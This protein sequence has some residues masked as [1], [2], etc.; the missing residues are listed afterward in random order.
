MFHGGF[1]DGYGRVENEDSLSLISKG[2]FSDGYN[3]GNSVDLTALNSLGGFADG[4]SISKLN[5]QINISSRGGHTDGYSSEFWIRKYWT[6]AINSVWHNSTNWSD[7]LVPNM[8]DQVIIPADCLFYPI[9]SGQRLL[10]GQSGSPLDF[11][12]NS[13]WIQNNASLTGSTTTRFESSNRLE[14]DG[15]F[16]WKN[17]SLYSI[18][19]NL[20]ATIKVG[21]TGALEISQ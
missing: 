14:I 3:L 19:N 20:G 15:N 6:G 16:Y 18:I 12:C 4:Y 10:I 17:V 2:K 1:S 13:L 9:L 11:I 21:S 7:A 5:N 8:N